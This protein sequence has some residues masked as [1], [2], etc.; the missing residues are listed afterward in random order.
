MAKIMDVI[1]FNT[2][3]H[4]YIVVISPDPTAGYAGIIQVMDMI[5]G[6]LVSEGMG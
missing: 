1:L 5:V 3:V 6:Y 4:G 2:V